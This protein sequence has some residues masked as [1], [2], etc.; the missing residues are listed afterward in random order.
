MRTKICERKSK[1]LVASKA[2]TR[3][4]PGV[5]VEVRVPAPVPLEVVAE[6]IVQLTRDPGS[7]AGATRLLEERSGG[8]ELGVR[9][10]ELP[11][12]LGLAAGHLPS[13]YSLTRAACAFL[14]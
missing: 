7:F 11:R 10:R 4:D 2:N 8:A 5:H 6:D 13:R 12:G 14:I 3:L 1:S 9:V